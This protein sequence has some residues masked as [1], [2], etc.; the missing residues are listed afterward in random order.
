M[1]TTNQQKQEARAKREAAQKAL[2]AKAKRNK[3]LQILGGIVFAALLVIVVIVAIG[4]GGGA[5]PDA[6]QGTPEAVEQGDVAGVEATNNLLAGI[7]QNGL[8]IGERDAPVQIVKFVDLQCPFCA[9]SQLDELPTVVNQLVKTGEAKLTLA[10]IAI[11]GAD[12]QDGRVVMAR[13]G[14]K[15]KAWQFA[16]LWYWNQGQENQGYATDAYLQGL[17]GKIDGTTDADAAREPD[18]AT[19]KTLEEVDRWQQELGISGTPTW[20]VGKTGDDVGTFDEVE[21]SAEGSAEPV[22][23]AVRALASENQ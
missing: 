6:E 23:E 9:S 18:E 10:P 22:T 3:Q 1:A 4:G 7:P 12:S 19:S 13:L 8:T 16:N 14:Q 15:D 20:V 17:L 5:G 21:I 2:E 11:L